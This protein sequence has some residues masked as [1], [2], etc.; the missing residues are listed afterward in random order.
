[1]A[2]G[3]VTIF[4]DMQ[5]FGLILPDIGTGEVVVPVGAL[6]RAGIERLRRGQR[7]AFKAEL[8]RHGRAAV[9]NIQL[10]ADDPALPEGPLEQS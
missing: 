7:V 8:D 1:M 3:T 2:N 5:G 6:Q 9:K 4:H 10:L